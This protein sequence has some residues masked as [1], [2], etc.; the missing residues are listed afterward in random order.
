MNKELFGLFFCCFWEVGY[1]SSEVVC[2]KIVCWLSE[3][4]AVCRIF[5]EIIIKASWANNY[6]HPYYK[7]RLLEV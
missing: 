2:W 1:G 6:Q 4:L 7:A 5:F 3:E